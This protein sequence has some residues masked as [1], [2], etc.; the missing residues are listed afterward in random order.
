MG[1]VSRGRVRAPAFAILLGVVLPAVGCGTDAVG[2][3]VCKQI[4]EARCRRAGACG[5]VLEP[6]YSTTGGPVDA[7]I[8]YYDVACLH[9]LANGYDPGAAPVRACI[10]A[11]GDDPC[12][13]GK[14]LV[15]H[16]EN[17]PACA[18]LVPPAVA[19]QQE[20]STAA[21]SDAAGD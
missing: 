3:D 18:W 14:D 5:V 9:G 21:D 4:E 1:V 10:A 2:I 16:P 20:A 11:I 15:A 12:T 6:P 17:D 8:R 7:C 19:L 13:N